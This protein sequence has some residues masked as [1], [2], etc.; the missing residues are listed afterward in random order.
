MLSHGIIQLI[1][2]YRNKYLNDYDSDSITKSSQQVSYVHYNLKY[3]NEH[4]YD[5]HTK[6]ES[7]KNCLFNTFSFRKKAKLF[8]LPNCTKYIKSLQR[9]DSINEK[10]NN[11]P[12]SSQRYGSSVHYKLIVSSILTKIKDLSK[13]QNP[14]VKYC[15]IVKSMTRKRT[16]RFRQKR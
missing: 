2:I 4:M 1:P 8:L 7:F 15:E 9:F 5:H 6:V 3:N 13:K 11:F 12:E 10:T 16:Y 14:G